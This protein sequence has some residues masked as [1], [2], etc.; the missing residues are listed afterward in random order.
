[1]R[2][3]KLPVSRG[4]QNSSTKGTLGREGLEPTARRQARTG[5]LAQGEGIRPGPGVRFLLL[6]Q[7]GLTVPPKDASIQNPRMWANLESAPLQI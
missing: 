2:G 1:M 4:P 3:R 7:E 5:P 6:Q